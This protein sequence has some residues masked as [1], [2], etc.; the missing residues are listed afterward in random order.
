MPVVAFLIWIILGLA[1]FLFASFLAFALGYWQGR[2]DELSG[3][4]VPD[5]R[6]L[7]LFV[8]SRF[9]NRSVKRRDGRTRIF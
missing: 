2:L 9:S 5:D 7:M 4:P 1:L 3:V 8:A 6:S